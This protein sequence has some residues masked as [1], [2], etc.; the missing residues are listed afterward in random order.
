VP[1][2][3]RRLRLRPGESVALG[4]RL[5]QGRQHAGRLVIQFSRGGV[6]LVAGRGCLPGRR[7]GPATRQFGRSH[8][9]G[10]LR[11]DRLDL[12]RGRVRVTDR[13]QLPHELDQPAGQRAS[14]TWGSS[15]RSTAARVAA[16]DTGRPRSSGVA[17]SARPPWRARQARSAGVLRV[18]AVLGRAPG[19][20]RRLE[21][22]DLLLL[23]VPKAR[24]VHR[25][26]IRFQGMR[27]LEVNLAAFIDE[28]GTIRYD[29][30]DLTSIRVFHD[31]PFLCAAVCHDLADT[32]I[33]LKELQAAP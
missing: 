15:S 23:T 3:R 8:L 20:A 2:S 33:S 5:L 1:S 28:P 25:D 9:L 29:P 16:I 26:G 19:R 22:L 21:D 14:M 18:V 7:L 13:P 30:R 27:Y 17:T 10:C 11:G 4:A 32:T 24:L 6:G 31:G 12:R